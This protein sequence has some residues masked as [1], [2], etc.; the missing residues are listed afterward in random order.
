MD[1]SLC[2]CMKV[3]PM[4]ACVHVLLILSYLLDLLLNADFVIEPFLNAGHR[5]FF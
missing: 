5:F 2:V 1:V 3:G 4:C